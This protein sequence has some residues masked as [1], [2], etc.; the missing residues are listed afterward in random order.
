MISLR[1]SATIQ[2]AATHDRW[3]I[4]LPYVPLAS[5]EEL[6]APRYALARALRVSS[7]VPGSRSYGS[8]RGL[9]DL[10]RLYLPR[11]VVQHEC[12]NDTHTIKQWMVQVRESRIGCC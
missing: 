7:F 6:R 4:A 1:I 10:E 8:S 12:T 2:A 5:P 9:L 3:G 11:N